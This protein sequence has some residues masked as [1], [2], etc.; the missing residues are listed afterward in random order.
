MTVLRTDR[1]DD[2]LP[3][4]VAGLDRMLRELDGEELHGT[5]S[6][7]NRLEEGAQV[8]VVEVDGVPVG[9]GAMRERGDATAEV[10]RMFVIP[11]A[12]G[13]G[14]GQAIL[15]ELET[16]ATELGH[17]YLLLET[18][19]DLADAIRLYLRFGFVRVPNY[20]PYDT[21]EHSVCFRKRISSTG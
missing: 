21:I 13:R 8:V 17:Q 18:S 1:D 2:R 5:L 11:S 6:V 7:Y 9:C 12:R 14:V 19:A 20:P 16:W 15:T 4:L 3:A 10:K